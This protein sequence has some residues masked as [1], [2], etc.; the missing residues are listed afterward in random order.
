MHG[1]SGGVLGDSYGKGKSGMGC[2]GLRPELWAGCASG[3]GGP[4]CVGTW[5]AG[6]CGG[7]AAEALVESLVGCSS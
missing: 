4:G 5:K 7:G 6:L 2:V 3:G 1:K